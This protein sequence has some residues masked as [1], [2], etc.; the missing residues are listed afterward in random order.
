M[1]LPVRC[2]TGRQESNPPVK[3][4]MITRRATYYEE[5]SSVF[6]EIFI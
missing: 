4:W 3:R 6:R 2:V 5:H 1:W